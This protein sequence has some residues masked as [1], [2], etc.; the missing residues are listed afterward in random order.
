MSEISTLKEKINTKTFHLIL[1]LIVTLGLY[2]F[3][4]LYKVSAAVE[5]TTHIKIMSTSFLVG[6]LVLVSI[7][8][9][10]AVIVGLIIPGLA[11][12]WNI[13]ILLVQVVW[14]FRV[15]RAIR[16]YTLTEHNFEPRI[17]RVFSVL[18]TF[19][20]INYCINALPR[21]KQKHERKKQQADDFVEA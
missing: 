6:Y 9:V 21:D 11:L 5:E 19:Y 1:L 16:A 8:G 18:L 4:W 10:L 15:R 3:V 2:S 13:S 14:C 12:L 20:H 17:N 7:G